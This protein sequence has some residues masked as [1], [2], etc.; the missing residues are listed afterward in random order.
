MTQKILLALALTLA[1]ATVAVPNASACG[2][3]VRVTPEQRAIT[4]VVNSFARRR[5]GALNGG[6]FV[7][8]IEVAGE[9]ATARVMYRRR[10]GQEA[11]R[12]VTLRLREGA[13]RVVS[14]RP[15]AA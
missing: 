14:A 10:D 3:Y 1:T 2:G 12:V 7:H 13:W 9:R 6:G 15:M 11:L 8:A 5:L 4:E